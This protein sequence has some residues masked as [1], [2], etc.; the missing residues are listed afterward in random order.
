[1]D[2]RL[3]QLGPLSLRWYGVLIASGAFVATYLAA[4]EAKRK[5]RNPEHVWNMLFFAFFLGLV[6]ARLYHVVDKWA[7]YSQNLVAI[8]AFW[9]GGLTG[10]GIYGGLVGGILGILVYTRWH[11]LDFLFWLDCIAPGMLLAQALGRWG[12]F[13]NQEAYGYPTTLPWGIHIDP[14]FRLPAF[15]AFDRFHP[16]F[17]YEFTWDALAALVLIYVA[18]RYRAKLL[19]GDLTLMY[20]IAYPVGR[21]WVE[22]L[23]ADS[24]TL[25]GFKMA[26]MIALTIVLVASTVLIERHRRVPKAINTAGVLSVGVV[27][28][29]AVP[30]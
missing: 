10:L 3:I 9:N 27:V 5:G 18:R 30:N 19:N 14:Q 24:W 6:G 13:F 22:S 16:T 7:Y 17:F 1:V 23:R 11:K 4:A 15:Q 2:P 26:Q 20:F 21:F 28:E 29:G 25:D 8:V 12:N